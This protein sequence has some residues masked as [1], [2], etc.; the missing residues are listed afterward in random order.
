M[1]T[2]LS[3]LLFTLFVVT[4]A[5][6]AGE[7]IVAGAGNATLCEE[8]RPE[9]CTA[10]YLPVC[11]NLADGSRKTYSNG[12]VACSDASVDSWVEAECTQ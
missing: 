10:Q 8:P 4:R 11:A 9:G 6:S 12:C 2:G 5:V 1:K 7:Q 3:I